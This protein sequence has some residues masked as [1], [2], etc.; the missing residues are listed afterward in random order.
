MELFMKVNQVKEHCHNYNTRDNRRGCDEKSMEK[1]IAVALLLKC[2]IL[3]R[4]R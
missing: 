2:G 4:W 3:L 1:W